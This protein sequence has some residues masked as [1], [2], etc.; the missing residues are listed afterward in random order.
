MKIK[1]DPVL[2]ETCDQTCFDICQ[3]HPENEKCISKCNDVCNTLYNKFCTY[4]C[5]NSDDPELC[6]KSCRPEFART[7]GKINRKIYERLSTMSTERPFMRIIRIII[8]TLL[9]L[10]F[11]ALIGIVLYLWL[12]DYPLADAIKYATDNNVFCDANPDLCIISPSDII[13]LPSFEPTYNEASKKSAILMINNVYNK[14]YPESTLTWYPI[15]VDHNINYPYGY[16]ATSENNMNYVIFR[17][18]D[19]ENQEEVNVDLDIKQIEINKLMC[20][21]GFVNEY[22]SFRNIITKHLDETLPLFVAGHSLGAAFALLTAMDYATLS[23]DVNSEYNIYAIGSP[24]VC[25]CSIFNSELNMEYYFNVQNLTD[26]IV[27]QPPAVVS[28]PKETN[29]L[30]NYC[31]AGTIVPFQSNRSSLSNNHSLTAYYHMNPNNKPIFY[32]I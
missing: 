12:R 7:C 16:I 25:S 31:T 17:G 3:D 29:S 15:F 32:D 9:S 28:L 2:N 26:P 5:K 22:K 10:A 19:V 30:Y 27:T 21:Q 24:R 13:E 20:H 23:T 18:T 6:K 8:I 1:P 4:S 14:T 11:I